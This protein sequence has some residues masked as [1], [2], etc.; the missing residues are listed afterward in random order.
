MPPSRSAGTHHTRRFIGGWPSPISLP[1]SQSAGTLPAWLTPT[2]RAEKAEVWVLYAM[3]SISAIEI[4]DNH[5][6]H[7]IFL[8]WS[9]AR[10]T[11][12]DHST[13]AGSH[14]MQRTVAV[15]SLGCSVISVT[16]KTYTHIGNSTYPNNELAGCELIRPRQPRETSNLKAEIEWLRSARATSCT[17]SFRHLVPYF[18]H[19]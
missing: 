14:T 9:L 2:A 13:P 6:A 11:H 12:S 3:M 1:I 18:L 15:S 4:I 17:T 8:R 10:F 16:D 7:V 5:Q 19:H